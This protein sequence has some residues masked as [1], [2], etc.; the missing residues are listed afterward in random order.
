M[1]DEY[2][3]KVRLRIEFSKIMAFH[4][5]VAVDLSRDLINDCRAW[6]ASYRLASEQSGTP[7]ANSGSPLGPDGA[8]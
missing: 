2:L 4:S 3:A 8:G 7:P 6:L 1:V 5:Q